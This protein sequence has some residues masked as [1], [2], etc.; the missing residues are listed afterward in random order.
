[1]IVSYKTEI[2]PTQEQMQKINQ[3]IGSIF[4]GYV[5]YKDICNAFEM[6]KY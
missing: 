3:T 2:N 5:N 4:T 6:I 1:M